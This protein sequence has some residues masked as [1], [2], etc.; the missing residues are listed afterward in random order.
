MSMDDNEH[1][2]PKG[3]IYFYSDDIS[4]KP[5]NENQPS[6][7]RNKMKVMYFNPDC[8][9]KSYPTLRSNMPT[10]PVQVP[11]SFGAPKNPSEGS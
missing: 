1:C 10:S 8:V 2:C 11:L 6:P 3:S 4:N 5:S 9:R 7:M